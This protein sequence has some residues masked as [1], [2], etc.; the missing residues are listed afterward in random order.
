MMSYRVNSLD[1]R[2]TGVCTGL[3]EDNDDPG[4]EGRV[5]VRFPWLDDRTLSEWCRV[6]QPYAGNR[7]GALFVPEVGDEVLVSFVHG[8]M[9]EPV[10]LGGMYN[11]SDLPPAFKQGSQD[12]VKM[13]RTKA[14]HELRFDDGSSS[15]AVEVKTAGGHKVTLDDQGKSITIHS[16]GGHS[17]TLD[18]QGRSVEVKSSVGHS[19]TLDDTAQSVAL[20]HAGGQASIRF[21]AAGNVTIQGTVV[22]VSGK[23]IFIG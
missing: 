10:V 9:N 17:V 4:K 7:Y 13:I 18:D 2:L 11:A 3:V 21:D 12:D 5:K 22:T 16:S 19:L 15:R 1:Q 20:A 6:C 14:G 8:D 23:Q